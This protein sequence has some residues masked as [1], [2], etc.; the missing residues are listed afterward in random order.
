MYKTID[1]DVNGTQVFLVTE[2]KFKGITLRY[3]TIKIV[4]PEGG[5][6]ETG[7]ADHVTFDFEVTGGPDGLDKESVEESEQFQELAGDIL[8]DFM[9]KSFD[10]GNYK[11]GDM[12]GD[13]QK[14][15]ISG[16]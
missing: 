5:W 7:E 12:V 3:G 8:F 15:D 4:P 10:E 6:D 1:G 16:S 14:V 13:T 11:I 9:Q 2:G